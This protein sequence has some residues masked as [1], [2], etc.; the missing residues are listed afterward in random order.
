MG[1]MKNIGITGKSGFIGSYISNYIR[2][3][4]KGAYRITDIKDVY[5]KDPDRLA[6]SVRSCDVILHLAGISRSEH[7]DI[8]ERNMG[9][10]RSLVDAISQIKT[11]PH[12]VFFSSIHENRK[13]SYGR[14]KKDSRL[15]LARW[16][17]EHGVTFTG[18]IIPNV[19]GPFSRPFYN[20]AVATFC[21]Q[22]VNG[23]EINIEENRILDLIYVDN[24]ARFVLKIVEEKKHASLARVPADKSISVAGLVRQLN[25]YRSQYL[26]NMVIPRLRRGFDQDLFNTLVSFIP[27]EARVVPLEPHKDKR[28]VLYECVKTANEGQSFFST[29]V[30]GAVRGNHFH[31]RKIERF[32]V[33]DGEA[34]IGLRK[35][36]SK[37][38][39]YYQLNGK[40][41]AIVDV[42]IWHTHNIINKSKRTVTSLFWS[43]EL[44]NPNDM[45]TYYEEV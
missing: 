27:K 12:V 3:F 33:I 16:A 23:Q 30:S 8:Y 42:P 25:V 28:G 32:C 21:Y 44:L 19:F 15:F 29:L 11:A 9:L 1:T 7:D 40:Q 26:E 2:V 5:F 45:D 20:S 36:G 13:D 24:L 10:T 4:G 41:P 14:S 18:L 35:I 31:I 34:E 39:D 6:R 17:K 37:K 38:I 22:M 43:N